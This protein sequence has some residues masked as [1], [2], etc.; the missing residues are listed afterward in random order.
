[1]D[2][3]DGGGS[4]W[5]KRR[6]IIKMEEKIKEDKAR[7]RKVLD[8]LKKKMNW[9][10]YLIL[11]VIIWINVKIRMLPLAINPITGKP[12][13][14]DVSR[15]AY[16]LG[17]DLDPFFFLRYAKIIVEQGS[18]PLIDLM[19]Y[20]PLGYNPLGETRLLPYSIAYFHKF[21]N[22]FSDKITVEYSAIIFPVVISVFTTIAF[23]LL[24]RKIFEE[25]GKMF[26][27]IT[28]LVASIF[29]VT[30]PSLLSRTIAGI[31]EKESLG[32][33]LMFFAF[34]FFLFAWKSKKISKALV[35]GIL[36]GIFTALMALVWGGS[37]FVFITIAI[38]GFITLIL[39]KVTK[40]SLIVYWSW[41]F[42]SM[43]FWI[44]FTLRMNLSLF[45][46]SSS[47]GLAIAVGF[48]MFVYFIMFK[49]KLKDTKILQNKIPKVIQVLIV[50]LLI[51]FILSSIIFGPQTL[52]D[53][54]KDIVSKL[55]NPYESRIAFTV[56]E[57]RQPFFNEWKGN[58]GPVV[59]KIPLFFW[60]FFIGSVFVF[61]EMIKKLKMK[62]KMIL[63]MSYILFLLALIFSRFSSSS[64]LNGETGLSMFVYVA[65]YIILMGGL[66]YV[67]YQRSK[68]NEFSIFKKIRFSY[69]FTFSLIFVGIIA[70]RS[71]IRLIMLL[72][73]M[74][75][76]PLSYLTVI[77][78]TNIYKNKSD[79]IKLFSVVFAILIL[80]SASYTLYYNYQVSKS[81]ALNHIP[82]SYTWQWQEAMGWV[83]EN[84]PTTAVFGKWWDYGYWIQTMGER[85]TMLDGGNGIPYWNYLMGRHVLTANNESEAL[86][87]LYN[88]NVTYFLIDST[89]IGK[90]SAYS[91]IGSDENYDK[92]SWIGTFLLDEAQTQE[93]RNQTTLSYF[94][95]VSLDEDIVINEGEV[96]LP[97]QNAGVG[98]IIVTIKEN[99]EFEQPY[100]IAV[101]KGNQYRIYLRYLFFRGEL[102]DFGSG[103]EGGA[104][105]FT[106]LKESGVNPM[107]AAMFLS[108]RNMRALWVR[109]YLLE[110]GENFELV[111]VETNKV[112]ESVRQQ[113]ID[114]PEIIYYNGIQGPIK[115]WK[116]NYVGD[117]EYN[118]E[119]VQKPFPEEIAG[120]GYV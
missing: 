67:F 91:N 62:E 29:L 43:V 100:A 5:N 15:N 68:V 20:V 105:I 113:G 4:K 71:A 79:L 120:R 41:L 17:P 39:G 26:S 44:P 82:N 47:G 24:V 32:F 78:V 103:V 59:Q 98:A 8:F 101:Y 69:I 16:T 21:L 42:S 93:T 38:A 52:F 88:H 76:I 86:G 104:Y 46:T 114:L 90:Y 30:L 55:S 66:G 18:L 53:I 57:N 9:I 33:A 54:G 102:L 75:V 87:V 49:T 117:E 64:I 109:L 34:Y 96:M 84:T 56:A 48:F 107:G 50:S 1:M 2:E 40:K 14:W 112:V 118:E 108:P 12:G 36:A 97:S 31:P 106:Q 110:E 99:R 60:L 23:F 94:G 27:N 70:G 61:Y 72:A 51:L 95:G 25:K 13:L 73:P 85:A 74:A 89:E 11:T 77:S 35:L 10:F 81:T 119:Y 22:F 58:F 28:A 92:F 65:G 116:V 45:L 115:I 83:R 63:V 80:I 111:H 3:E 19:R 37:I 7:E 6:L